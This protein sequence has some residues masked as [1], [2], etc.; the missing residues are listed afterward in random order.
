MAKFGRIWHS[1]E[2]KLAPGRRNYSWIYA[3]EMKGVVFK[4][5][6]RESLMK[7]ESF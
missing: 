5:K 3:A 2:G 6:Y 7:I 4:D 1:V